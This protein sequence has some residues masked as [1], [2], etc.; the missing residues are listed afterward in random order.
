MA[1]WDDLGAF[2]IIPVVASVD[3]VGAARMQDRPDG[4]LT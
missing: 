1:R 3:A 2:E 4:S